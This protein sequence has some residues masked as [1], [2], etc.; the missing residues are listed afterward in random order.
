MSALT[1]HSGIPC[2][3]LCVAAPALAQMAGNPSVDAVFR[4]FT[5]AGSPGCALGIYRDGKMIYAKGYGLANV[6]LEVPITPASVFDIG[7]TSKQFTAASIL[8]LEKQGKLRLD[9]DIR[10]YLPELPEYPAPHGGTITILNLLNHTSGVRDYLAL[11][12]MAGIPMD[13]VTTDDT[14]LAMLARQKALNFPPGSDFL[15][16]NSGYFLLSIIVK[17][18]SGQSLRGFARDNIFTPLG[19]LH[20]EYRDDHRALIRNRALAYDPAPGGFRLDVSYFEQ[21]GDGA[22]HTSVEDL[23]HWDENFYTAQVGGNQL[24]A[25]IQEPGKLASGKALAYAKGLT[26][27]TYRG[28]PFVSHGGAWGGYR[29]QL[30]RFPGQHFSVA[31]LCNLE[32]ANPEALAIQTSEVFLADRMRAKD[33][34]PVP[35]APENPARAEPVPPPDAGELARYT[36][37]Y[38]SDELGVIYRLAMIDGRL[39]LRTILDAGGFPR[40]TSPAALRAT[41]QD[42]FVESE[43][44]VRLS[45]TMDAKGI[46]T[47]FVASAGRTGGLVFTRVPA[48]K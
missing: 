2:L 39:S 4:N 32:T 33:S 46:P 14:A 48:A 10:K 36:G 22:V 7:S 34:P 8:L 16:S 11:F 31:C 17:R 21:L 44:G 42:Q 41:R 45:F 35:K 3:V 1:R 24:L 9:D 20:T 28:L 19:M 15:Y 27:G 43:S 30:L 18:V 12:A 13:G 6:E 29:A 37:D 5:K 23:L 40:D 26:L 47:S 38:A 25:E